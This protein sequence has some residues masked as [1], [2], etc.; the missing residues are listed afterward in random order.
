M[1]PALTARAAVRRYALVSFLTWLPP[2]LMTAPM[3]LLMTERGLGLGEAGTVMAAYGAVVVLLELPTGG[4][5]DVIGRRG[6][7]AASALVGAAGLTVMAF[8]GSFWPFLLASLL[9]GVARALSSGPAQAWYVDTLHAAEGP[10]ADLKPG[11]ARGEAAGSLALCLGV[12]AGGLL[13][14][15]VARLGPPFGEPLAVPVL[16]AAV[17]SVGLFAVVLA[18]LPEPPH[19]RAS[20]AG[21]LR[22]VPRTVGAGLALA[23]RDGVLGR[24]LLVSGAVGVALCAVELLTPVRLARLAGGAE[25]GGTA[26][27]LVT[28]VGFAASAAGSALAP[29]VA[30]LAGSSARGAALGT[31]LLAV[32]LGVLAASAT[33]PGAPGLA[34]AAGAYLAMFAGMSVA[35]LLRAEIMHRRVGAARRATLISVDSLALQ[36]GACLANLGLGAL[37]DAHGPGPAWWVAGGV[38][39]L[40]TGL[41][42]GVRAEAAL[43]RPRCRT[44]FG[45]GAES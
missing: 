26:Y 21:V 32:S 45:Q 27:G 39:L 40:A 29:R 35:G 20:L 33:L 2:G 4:L 9:K 42:R 3:I 15:A 12:L 24:L 37:A 22:G 1:P 41:Y 36:L 10:G 14:P 16:L 38:V 31:A 18:A 13:P 25:A 30:R 17:A 7:L 34:V 8:A 11:L 23:A 19:P 43:G 6:V 5:A 44:W 28:A